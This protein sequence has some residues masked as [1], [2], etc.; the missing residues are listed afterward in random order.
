MGTGRL[1]AA[2]YHYQLVISSAVG[3][4]YGPD[5]IFSFEPPTLAYT[6]PAVTGTSAALSLQVN[7][8]GLDTTVSIQYGRTAACAGGTVSVGDIGSGFAP[9]TVKP[10][11]AG[12][13]PGR[14][15][16]YRVVTRNAL[17]T[18]Y[19]PVEEFVTLP[20]PGT[21]TNVPNTDGSSGFVEPVLSGSDRDEGPSP[22][23]KR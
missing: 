18:T 13:S 6:A 7:P 20:L 22:Q 19:G 14:A 5:Q 15:C 21:A 3:F 9:V 10:G 2:I 4:S 12:L 11:I 1:A 17:G 23:P 16:A 8:N